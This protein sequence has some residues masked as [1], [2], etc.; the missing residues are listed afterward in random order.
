MVND[1]YYEGY[2]S[3]PQIRFESGASELIIWEGYIYTLMENMFDQGLKILADYYSSDDD[4]W[5][6]IDL[7]EAIT[8]FDLFDLNRLDSEK[9]AHISSFL[10]DIAKEIVKFLIKAQ[11]QNQKVHISKD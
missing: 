7:K 3:E 2:E 6:I 11:M 8:Q 1:K 9:I 10:P 5:E 4:S